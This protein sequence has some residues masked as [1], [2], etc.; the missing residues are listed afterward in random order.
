MPLMS[1][2]DS[3]SHVLCNFPHQPSRFPLL[4]ALFFTV[5]FLT[6]AG[7]SRAEGPKPPDRVKLRL[8]S[9]VGTLT[10]EFKRTDNSVRDSITL[11]PILVDGKKQ[12]G[13]RATGEMEFANETLRLKIQPVGPAS[14]EII[15]TTIDAVSHDF[16]IA[17]QDNSAYYGGGERFTS[18]NHKGHILPM[19]SI[20]QPGDKGSCSYKPVPFYMS[21][22]GYAAWLDHSS[23]GTFDFNAT[24]REHVFIK[25]RAARLRLVLIDGPDMASMLEEFTRLTGRP[26]VPPAWAFA[27]WKSRNIHN[28]RE[29]V[30]F[31]AEMTR[32]NDLPG[33]VIVLDSPWETGYNDFHLNVT[34]FREPQAMFKRL[35]ELGF[36][37][38]LWLTP[39]IN[40]ENLRDMPGI[41]QGPSRNFAEAERLGYL[42]KR[43]DG[44]PMIVDWWKGRGGLVDFTNP[45][46]VSWWQAQIDQARK[47]NLHAL[48]CDDG[49]GNFVQDAV[50]YDGTSAADM[51]NRY[52]TLYLKA[53]QEYVDK[54]LDGDGVLFARCGF[55]GTQAQ[56]FCWAGDNAADFSFENGLPTAILAGQN[57]AL[58]GFAFWGHDIAGYI[59]RQTKELFIR[60]AQFGALSPLMQVHMQSNLGPWDFDEQTLSIYRAFA[61]LH[62]SLYPYLNDAAHEAAEHG[63]PLIRPMVLAFPNDPDAAAHR[64][65]Y[66]LGP[67]L[68]VAPMYQP[69][70][71]RSVYLPKTPDEAPWID[72]WSGFSYPGGQL[73]EAVAPLARMPLY[74]R[75]GAIFCL[76]PRTVDTLISRYPEMEDKIVA[77]DAG[78]VI[79]IW[80]G[81]V[82]SLKTYDGLSIA[83][84]RQSGR[85]LITLTSS[86]SR[87]VDVQRMFA[88]APKGDPW[89][90]F[91]RATGAAR[92]SSQIGPEP[93]ALTWPEN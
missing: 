62:T 86:Y 70:T 49:E 88:T 1:D 67:D 69:G 3:N 10:A 92:C 60:W 19:V 48:K 30:L 14:A 55:T 63:L 85:R 44:K 36:H 78:R 74:V 72:Y 28:N 8:D 65:Q 29:E 7:L 37:T 59:G 71:R 33:S 77:L 12:S 22:R 39:M 13:F 27:P 41:D 11:P 58:S 26:R 79:Q 84:T 4:Q 52:A 75:G 90:R 23:A 68:L 91:D 40:I 9:G 76:L 16:V 54:K 81:P 66:L 21:T 6:A 32:R 47:W 2:L 46:A 5:T 18:L 73:I 80:P 89:W 61:K 82:R 15:W 42:V 83:M 24:D 25:Y 53:A 51:K 64:Y 56:P 57:A 43:P 35:R 17:I 31:D 93:T 34:Q 20:D 38:C 50:F 45:A 87:P